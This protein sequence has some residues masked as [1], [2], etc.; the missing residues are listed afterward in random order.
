M[1]IRSSIFF[2]LGIVLPTALAQDS[3]QNWPE[4]TSGEYVISDFTF[5]SGEKLDELK[6]HYQTLGE[7]KVDEDGHTNA[8]FIMHGSTVSSDQFLEDQFA[9][10]LFNPGQILDAEDYFIILRDSIGHGN[11]SKPS[12]TGLR[13]HFPSYQYSDMVR[14]DHQLLTE[15]FG[16]NHTRLIMGVS[17]GGMHTWLWGEMYPDFMDALMPISSLPVQIGGHNRLWRKFVLELITI[18][19]AYKGGE[20]D[21]TPVAGL[22]GALLIQQVMLSSAAYYQREYPTRDAV[23]NYVEYLLPLID[24]YD[25]NDQLFAWNAS[26]TYDPEADLGLIKVPLVAVN[27]ADDMMN[28]P[29]LGILERTVR[30]QMQPGLG[31]AVIIP[32]SDET[33]GHNSHVKAELWKDELEL[34]LAKTRRKGAANC[35]A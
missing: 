1:K 13:A 11:S 34:L 7:L 4:T 25:A 15:H 29:E 17:M 33:T 23:D 24:H 6:L 31:K 22:G 20:Y 2:A 8:V 21:E 26:H 32:E 28:P 16:I 18:D 5:D 9:G 35:L 10:V 14:A 3:P 12:N 30:A 27:T 19:P